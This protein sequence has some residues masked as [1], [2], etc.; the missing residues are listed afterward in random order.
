VCTDGG[1]RTPAEY[2]APLESIGFRTIE[3]HRTGSLVDA[4]LA[5]KD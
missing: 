2:Y 5:I 1:E 3:Y 4:V